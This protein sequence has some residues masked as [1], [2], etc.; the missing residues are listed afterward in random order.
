MKNLKKLNKTLIAASL[1]AMMGS[2][3]AAITDSAS[4]N[5]IGNIAKSVSVSFDSTTLDLGDMSDT[6]IANFT[7][8][9]NTDYTVSAP[10]AGKLVN[11]DNGAELD[12]AV[13]VS[14]ENSTMSITPAQISATQAAGNYQAS[15]VLVV[16]AV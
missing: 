12:F 11:V 16:A 2:S 7:V 6:S 3:F 10:T 1:T 9:A 5:L 15:V 14:K 4:I 13:A 8:V